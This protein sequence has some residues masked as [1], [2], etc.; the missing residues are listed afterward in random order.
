VTTALPLVIFCSFS[1]ENSKSEDSTYQFKILI[2][3]LGA[4]SVITGCIPIAH[5]Y[6]YIRR[7]RWSMAMTEMI[8]DWE[9]HHPQL[10]IA[11]ASIV[12]V[13]VAI[14]LLAPWLFG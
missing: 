14:L 8:E 11:A 9:R 13:A 1:A 7:N 10:D 4:I 12:D 2:Q 3:P 6:G 5:G